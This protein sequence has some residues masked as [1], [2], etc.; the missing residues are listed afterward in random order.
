MLGKWNKN[1]VGRRGGLGKGG[2]LEN[3][4]E[5]LKGACEDLVVKEGIEHRF[6]SRPI[7]GYPLL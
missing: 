5:V 7:T 1:W 4:G 3:T 6:R 2:V